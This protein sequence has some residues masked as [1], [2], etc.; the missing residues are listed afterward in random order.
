MTETLPDLCR[1]CEKRGTCKKPCPAVEKLLWKDNRVMERHY[2]D[3]IVSYPQKKEVRFSEMSEQYFPNEGKSRKQTEDDFSEDCIIPWSSGDCRLRHTTVFIERFFNKTPCKEL[4]ERFGVK[5]NTIVCM[6][7]QAVEQ[8]EKIINAM[9]ARREGL[10]A[11]RPCNRLTEDQKIF[12]MVT[13][14]GFSQAEMGRIFGKKDH[15]IN[16]KMRKMKE[17]YADLFSVIDEIADPPMTDVTRDNVAALVG[18]YVDQGL[19]HRQAFIR[20]ADRLNGSGKSV[21]YRGIEKK[22]YLATAVA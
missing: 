10:K 11:V 14:F 17:K 18:A 5:E 22:Y 6:Y 13:V 2:S 12:L 3:K 21:S 9:D 19:S 8:L 20:I 4:A 16:L 1:N 7:A 15:I